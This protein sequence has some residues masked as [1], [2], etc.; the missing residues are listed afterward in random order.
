MCVEIMTPNSQEAWTRR[1]PLRSP[2][3][4]D[5]WEAALYNNAVALSPCALEKRCF[6]VLV[7]RLMLESE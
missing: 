4:C 6:T 1:R 5:V 3:G 2:S 7:A